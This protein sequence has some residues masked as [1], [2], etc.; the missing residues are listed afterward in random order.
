MNSGTHT[1]CERMVI[2]QEDV[3][4][5]QVSVWQN[6]PQEVQS[7]VCEGVKWEKCVWR[8]EGLCVRV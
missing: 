5:F 1:H 8:E 7:V 3:A 6:R 2:P 4:G